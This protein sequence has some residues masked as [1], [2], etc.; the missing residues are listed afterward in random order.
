MKRKKAV[1]AYT[2]R[3]RR[4]KIFNNLASFDIDSAGPQCHMAV[5]KQ[6]SALRRTKLRAAHINTATRLQ[7]V[8]AYRQ[9]ETRYALLQSV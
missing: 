1:R 8:P 3:V 5:L 9:A 7:R 2:K 4:V 6:C